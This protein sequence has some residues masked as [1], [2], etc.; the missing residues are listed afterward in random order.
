MGLQNGI[1]EGL[2]YWEINTLLANNVITLI[3]EWIYVFTEYAL[4]TTAR[5]IK[6][7]RQLL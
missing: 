7:L 3:Y 5:K 1:D 4:R 2:V 6:F